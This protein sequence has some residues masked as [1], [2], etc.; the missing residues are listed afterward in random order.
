M[1]EH[2]S[3]SLKEDDNLGIHIQSCVRPYVR[4][5]LVGARVGSYP[6]KIQTFRQYDNMNMRQLRY[7]YRVTQSFHREKLIFRSYQLTQ[8]IF[9]PFF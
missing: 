3:L 8:Y 2:A 5:S 7:Y 1:N 4:T 6:F 9:E